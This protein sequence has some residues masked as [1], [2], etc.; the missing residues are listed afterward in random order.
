MA[1]WRMA[2]PA[3]RSV[4]T[5]I[6]SAKFSTRLF[7]KRTW[8]SAV[9]VL[10]GNIDVA[11]AMM[12]VS[13]HGWQIA[14][15]CKT[16]FDQKESVSEWLDDTGLT[17][18]LKEMKISFFLSLNLCVRQCVFIDRLELVEGWQ[19]GREGC[20][21]KTSLTSTFFSHQKASLDSELLS[22]EWI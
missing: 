19:R 9:F 3:L 20:I 5:S 16:L 13:T 8:E 18:V 11:I 6:Q 10:E 15:F 4:I 22:L 1:K 17:L 7:F 21:E 14:C 2:L 12:I